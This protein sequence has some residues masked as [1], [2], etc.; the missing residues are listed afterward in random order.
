[1]NALTTY[2]PNAILVV[3]GVLAM[4]IGAA[5]ELRRRAFGPY[6]WLALWTAAAWGLLAVAVVKGAG[7]DYSRFAYLLLPP[8]VLA[9]AG[10][11]TSVARALVP[12]SRLGP[13]GVR[14][15][16]EA[17]L[18]VMTV[19]ATLAAPLAIDNYR[20]RAKVFV[21]PDDQAALRAIGRLDVALAGQDSTILV[22]PP[23]FGANVEAFTGR[24]TLTRSPI[25]YAFRAGQW[26]R[27]IDATVLMSASVA[28]TNENFLVRWSGPLVGATQVATGTLTVAANHGGEFV[29]LLSL[30]PEDE[31]FLDAGALT[32]ATLPLGLTE[33]HEGTDRV[34]VR[35]EWRG[36][37]DDIAFVA[38]TVG[39]SAEADSMSIT[40]ASSAG[41][42][43]SLL[44]V[45]PGIALASYE[46]TGD[47]EARLCFSKRGNTNPCVIVA[48]EGTGARLIEDDKAF[49]IEGGQDGRTTVRITALSEGRSFVGLA[50]RDPTEIIERYGVGAVVL[51]VNS[52]QDLAALPRLTAL[53]FTETFDEGIY[54]V[55]LRPVGDPVSGSAP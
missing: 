13:L 7:T 20:I 16:G 34:D 37:G 38:R 44:R 29:N 31:T 6:L 30:A 4:V 11:I 48:V 47:Q 12:L 43:R 45:A 14:S 23:N 10:G 36:P 24:P 55:L 39:L 54:R 15:R 32:L 9:A 27:S 3:A 21:M 2:L 33:R 28:L 46:S 17:A 42:T 1:V 52:P 49:A 41:P 53:G 51:S 19:L 50:L 26:E 35:T 5:R 8:L 22:S 40:E 18:V 25:R